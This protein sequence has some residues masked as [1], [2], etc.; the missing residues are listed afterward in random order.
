MVGKEKKKVGRPPIGKK[1]AMTPAE[2]AARYRTNRSNREAVELRRE[3]RD[4]RN[5]KYAWE[6]NLEPKSTRDA[7]K[8]R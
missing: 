4:R 7:H 3:A 2:R 5:E 1:K 6:H 8:A